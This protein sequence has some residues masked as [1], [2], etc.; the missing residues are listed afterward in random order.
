MRR[1]NLLCFAVIL[2][3]LVLCTRSATS[4]SP[5]GAGMRVERFSLFFAADRVVHARR[6]RVRHRLAAAR[7]A[8]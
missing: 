3:A 5:S 4:S 2:M 1:L 6:D 8:T 7:A